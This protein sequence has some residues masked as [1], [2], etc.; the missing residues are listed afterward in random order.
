[1]TERRGSAP[2]GWTSPTAILATL[3]L[4][5]SAGWAYVGMTR[6][7]S[8]ELQRQVN[9][10]TRDIAVLQSQMRRLER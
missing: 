5:S 7:D 9:E 1:V 3:A 8:K 2:S 10:H 4:I 6:D